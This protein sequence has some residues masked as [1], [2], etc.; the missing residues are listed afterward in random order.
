MDA[1]VLTLLA[2]HLTI[3]E[4]YR[5]WIALGCVEVDVAT[6]RSVTTRM[7]LRRKHASLT[8]LGPHMRTRCLACGSHTKRRLWWKGVRVCVPCGEGTGTVALRGRKYARDAYRSGGVHIP[9]F[10]TRLKR[11]SAVALTQSGHAFLY[12]KSDVDALLG[13]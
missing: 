12:W 8:T 4:V 10:E 6:I 1:M 3:A 9:Y 7:G 5:V 13:L 2:D 11:L